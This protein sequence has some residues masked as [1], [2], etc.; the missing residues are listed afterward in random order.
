MEQIVKNALE[1]VE[2]EQGGDD[3]PSSRGTDDDQELMEVL[4][5]ARAGYS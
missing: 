1:R 4:E 3:P 2:R 5:R